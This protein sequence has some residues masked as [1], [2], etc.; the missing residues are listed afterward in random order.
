MLWFF[1]SCALVSEEDFSKRLDPDGD[2]IDLSVDC[3]STKAQIG[4]AQEWFFD[5]DGDGYGDASI[6]EFFCDMPEEGW[7]LSNTDCDDTNEQINLAAVELC[8]G[9]DNNCDDVI[10]DV[11]GEASDPLGGS[12]YYLDDDEDGYGDDGQVVQACTQ[13]DGY[14]E[15][16]GDCDDSSP[17]TYPQAQELCDNLDNNCDGLIDNDAEIPMYLDMDGDGYTTSLEPDYLC[18]SFLEQGYIEEKKSLIDCDDSDANTFPGQEEICD[19]L[20]NNCDFLVDEGLVAN[21]FIDGDGDGFGSGTS[22]QECINPDGSAPEGYALVA[23]DCDDADGAVNPDAEEICDVIVDNDCDGL[24]D[25]GVKITYF[26]DADG[27]G[28]GN[29]QD[30]FQ[31]CPS[32]QYTVQSGDCNDLD[33]TVFPGAPELCDGIDNNC[34]GSLLSDEEDG[35]QDGF[36]VCSIDPGGWDGSNQIAGGGDCDD[37]SWVTYPGAAFYDSTTACLK[38]ADGDGFALD[39]EGGTDCNDADANISPNATEIAVDGVDQN[40]DGFEECPADL[41]G[42]GFESLTNLVQS[43]N[44]TC[45]LVGEEDC[46]DNDG[47]I[48]PNAPEY[49]SSVDYNCDGMEA[50]DE[51]CFSI[52]VNGVYFL[53][54]SEGVPW[55][56]AHQ[57]CNS[58]GY[59]FAAIMDSNENSEV[60]SMVGTRG[61]W[62]G[63]YDTDGSISV[64]GQT[65]VNFQWADGQNGSYIKSYNPNSN[66]IPIVSGGSY[67]NWKTGEP[68]NAEGMEGCAVVN[69]SG[70][71][72]DNEC[73]ANK[74][75][76]CEIR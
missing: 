72:G 67:H 24:I 14:V 43:T 47:A 10:D 75:Y 7:V 15:L 6:S 66:C 68:D 2:G 48:Y 8:D 28:Y 38:D 32:A 64:C 58:A 21:I 42:D 45:G 31:S 63:Y 65:N 40:C 71:W 57:R 41:D 62:I 44:L 73:S 51:T 46:D 39:S 23:G 27:D 4:E 22:V 20:D 5:E 49:N 36:V 52:D 50:L 12:L 54:C 18:P 55:S 37:Q 69:D 25:E 34:N 17:E 59:D 33:T 29:T 1:V 13:P 11:L 60:T 35:D 56:I 61:A 53:L 74:D 76:I 19:G 9:V 3:D 16:A 26:V 30:S 70:R